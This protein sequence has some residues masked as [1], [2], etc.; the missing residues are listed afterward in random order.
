MLRILLWNY[1]LDGGLRWGCSPKPYLRGL[2]PQTPFFRFA[3]VLRIGS[4]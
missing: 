4:G 2:S 1:F 3:A